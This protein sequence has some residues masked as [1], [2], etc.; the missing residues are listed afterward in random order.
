MP[1]PDSKKWSV[2][3]ASPEPDFLRE[4]L[5]QI[6]RDAQTAPDADAKPRNTPD[7][8]SAVRSVART[9]RPRDR[10]SSAFQPPAVTVTPK[11]SAAASTPVSPPANVTP[12]HD[13]VHSAKKTATAPCPDAQIAPVAPAVSSVSAPVAS[14]EKQIARHHTENRFAGDAAK[15]PAA[16]KPATR[17]AEEDA[18]RRRAERSKHNRIR[19][20]ARDARKTDDADSA[21]SPASPDPDAPSAESS[22]SRKHRRSR[23][24]KKRLHL[25]WIILVTVLVLAVSLTAAWVAFGYRSCEA[26]VLRFGEALYRADAEAVFDLYPEEVLED[27]M[28][29][30]NMTDRD[31]F[32]VARSL[33]LKNKWNPLDKQLGLD[34]TADFACKDKSATYEDNLKATCAAYAVEYGITPD[35]ARWIVLYATLESEYGQLYHTHSVIMVRF[36]TW[37]YVYDTPNLTF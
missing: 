23:S 14:P 20:A 18:S 12:G 2:P 33:S 34:W 37:W 28:E 35:E 27:I 13:T 5:N 10:E 1:F 15:T 29:R 25:A 26:T 4:A 24:R 6:H 31:H 7:I 36:G 21:V 9:L 16:R 11:E 3:D 32:F 8:R 17:Y 22:P 19:A 30:K